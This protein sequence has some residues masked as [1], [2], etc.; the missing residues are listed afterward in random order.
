MDKVGAMVAG[1]VM[2]LIL[3]V[4]PAGMSRS[5]WLAA[6]VSCLCICLA[7]GLDG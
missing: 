7:Y 2:L 4:L 5:A 6:G 3:C 1:G